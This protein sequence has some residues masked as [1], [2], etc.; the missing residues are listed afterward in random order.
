MEEQE[1]EEVGR[2]RRHSQ[3]GISRRSKISSRRRKRVVRKTSLRKRKVVRM[4]SRRRRKVRRAS[5][6]KRSKYRKP[7]GRS[8][9]RSRIR[10]KGNSRRRPRNYRSSREMGHHRFYRLLKNIRNQVLHGK[11]RK[12]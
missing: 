12:L 2:R 1:A 9:E 7:G 3:G 4:T 8:R 11:D 6:K 5:Q 10:F